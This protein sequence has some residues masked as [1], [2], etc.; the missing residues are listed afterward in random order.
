MLKIKNDPEA[1]EEQSTGGGE[2]RVAFLAE[3]SSKGLE[4]FLFW[5]KKMDI[6]F[7]L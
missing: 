2:G 3:N 6:Q 1:T 4:I 7:H 5:E